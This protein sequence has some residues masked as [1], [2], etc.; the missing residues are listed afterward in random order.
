VLIVHDRRKPR[1]G[2]DLDVDDEAEM[3]SQR[4]H[5]VQRHPA[6]PLGAGAATIDTEA[7]LGAAIDAFRPDVLHVHNLFP[8]LSTAVYAVAAA[9]RV[10]LVQTLHDYR[11][12]CP[13][14]QLFRDGRPCED[15]VGKR[16]WPAVVHNCHGSGRG[17]AMVAARATVTMRRQSL[18][19]VARFIAP[20]TFVRE[21]ALA[22]GLPAERVVV[23]PNSLDLPALEE[24]F[25]M[26]FLCAGRLSAAKGIDVLADAMRYEHLE[27]EVRVAG[28]GPARA[29]VESHPRLQALGALSPASVREEMR[30]AIALVMPSRA[31]EAFPRALVEA[32]ALGLPVIASRRGAL[33][34]LVDDGRTGLLFTPGSGADLAAKLRWAETHPDRMGAMGLAAR[35]QYE[36]EFTHEVN[37]PRLMAVYADAIAATARG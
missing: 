27:G 7:A 8:G 32:F 29:E 19:H 23:K 36:R 15:C 5:E 35:R 14:G 6:G 26:G 3:L 28:D 33:A 37:Y 9:R 10:A 30:R 25:R 22:A 24:T 1:G 34:S 21:R 31:Y 4:G 2:A 17:E 11:I 20:S 12:A 13:Q 18:R 16:P